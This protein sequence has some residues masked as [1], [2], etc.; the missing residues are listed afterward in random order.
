MS[1]RIKSTIYV[2]GVLVILACI[3]QADASVMTTVIKDS[4]ITTAYGYQLARANRRSL[5]S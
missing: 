2:L 4:P 5:Q 3:L 1:L